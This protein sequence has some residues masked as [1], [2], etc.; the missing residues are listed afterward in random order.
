[1]TLNSHHEVLFCTAIVIA[2]LLGCDGDAPETPAP[3]LDPP[4]AFAVEEASGKFVGLKP[5]AALVDPFP[6]LG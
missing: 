6:D 3:N 5:D 1:M 2:V 4:T